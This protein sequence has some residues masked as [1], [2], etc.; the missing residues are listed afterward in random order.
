MIQNM[1][2]VEIAELKDAL[3]FAEYQLA[4]TNQEKDSLQKEAASSMFQLKEAEDRLKK[5]EFVKDQLQRDLDRQHSKVET[6]ERNQN[7]V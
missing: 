5:T 3:A 4:K 6:I 2:G 7:D 1:A